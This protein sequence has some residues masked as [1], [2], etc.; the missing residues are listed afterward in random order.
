MNDF[1]RTEVEHLKQRVDL[2]ELMRGCGLQLERTGRN[3]MANCPFHDDDTA[4]LS[5]NPEAQLWNCFGC[6]AG[7]DALTFLQRFE[8]L[9]FVQALER[10]REV[11]GGAAPTQAKLPKPSSEELPGGYT[12][13]GLLGRIAERY[14]ERFLECPKPQRYLEK[15]GLL[16]TELWQAFR[17]GYAD[18]SLLDSIPAEGEL[19]EA[20]MQLG[21][22]T[23]KGKEFFQG[24][25]V[26]PL[27]HPDQGILGFYGRRLSGKAKIK[28]L[29]L[30]GP[31]RGV[32]NGA[33][34]KT[35]KELVIAE[36]VLD[37]M[38][39][40]MAGVRNATCLYG[41]QGLPPDLERLIGH[42]GV[43]QIKLVLD[44]DKAGREAAVRLEKRLGERPIQ[45]AIVELGEGQDPNQFLVERGPEALRNLVANTKTNAPTD[46]K[47][48]PCRTEE[49]GFV[50]R[51]GELL[52]RVEPRPPFTGKLK[53]TL[54]AEKDGRKFVDTLDLLSHRARVAAINQIG[55]RFQ[56]AKPTAE[57]HFLMLLE[58]TERWVEQLLAEEQAQ[59]KNAAAQEEMTA[60]ERAEALTFLRSQELAQA[61]LEDMEALGY[62]GEDQGKLLGYLIGISRKL[63]RPMAGVVTSQSGA[64]KSGLTELVEQLTPPEDVVLYSRI[65]AQALGYL[66]Q[67]FLKN[68][69]LILEERVGGE[70]ADYSIRVLQSRQKLSQAVVIKDPTSGSM[71]T[72]HFEVEGPIAYLETTT[73]PHINYE[74]ATRCFE[75]NLDESQRQTERIHQRQREAR[76]LARFEKHP[77]KEVIRRRH[78]NAQRLLQPVKVLIPF[79]DK[80]SFP[81]RWLRTRRDH[82]RFLCLIEVV[83]FLHQHQRKRGT[84]AA[85]TGEKLDYIE[86]TPADYRL[87]YEL[88]REVLRATLHELST[89]ARELLGAIHEMVSE[90]EKPPCKVPFGRRQLRAH[91]NWPD[92]RLRE[93]LQELVELE[94]LAAHGSQGRAYT[95]FLLPVEEQVS[96]LAQLTT[97]EQLES[98][99]G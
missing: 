92:R 1:D 41:V 67:D 38:S 58:E 88:A 23:A 21:V 98:L 96:P 66:P 12:R 73:N 26:V 51:F 3:L 20:L 10:L 85:S 17:V 35:N 32:I 18:G 75:I 39:L 27:E 95:Y 57:D 36:G 15:R 84:V 60:Q 78:H 4:S 54:R 9:S 45:V 11:A 87:A 99:Y 55:R 40:W 61:I 14:A 82:E 90:D 2:A 86:A 49:N 69:L 64:G 34:L 13:S 46:Q 16:S 42:Y 97:P 72:K 30:P 31:R 89:G 22:L 50:L 79:V 77:L 44:G 83:A 48:K 74:N 25:V 76:T 24:C 8:K 6:E 63:E 53:V 47:P 5:V 93:T 52:Y 81:T 91:V 28:H 71:K 37:A 33:S 56:V 19:H 94:Y 70:A 29:Y 80:L 43:S 68:K 62:V 7:G 65:S 59:D